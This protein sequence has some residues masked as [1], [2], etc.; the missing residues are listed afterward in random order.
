MVVG[1]QHHLKVVLYAP[2]GVLTDKNIIPCV[3]SVG[4]I[5]K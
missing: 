3:M 1:T 4:M 5:E 2:A